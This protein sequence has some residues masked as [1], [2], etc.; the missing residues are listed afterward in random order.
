LCHPDPTKSVSWLKT[1]KCVKWPNGS[2][3]TLLTQ[4]I[5]SKGKAIL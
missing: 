4:I 1:M 5:I 2:H 3:G